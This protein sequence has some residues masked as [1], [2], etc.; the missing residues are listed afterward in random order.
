MS[1]PEPRDPETGKARKHQEAAKKKTKISN[2]E[3]KPAPVSLFDYESV[4][5]AKV[6]LKEGLD[7]PYVAVRSSILGGKEEVSILVTVSKDPESEWANHILQN[8]RY[9]KIHILRDGTVE[10]FV[11]WKLK[12]R[13]F[14]GKSIEHVIEK[15]NKIKV[16]E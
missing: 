5:D 8:S 15:I 3:I 4:E 14:K 9:A 1:F 10:Q 11:G 13:K 6:Q 16:V 12:M 2:A 7:F